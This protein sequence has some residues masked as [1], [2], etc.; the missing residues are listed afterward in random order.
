MHV[1]FFPRVLLQFLIAAVC[2]GIAYCA[3][4]NAEYMQTLRSSLL[5]YRYSWLM[6]VFEI[7][8]AGQSAKK[9]QLF[10]LT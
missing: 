4:P 9:S 10:I 6:M 7:A 1:G 8:K 5:Y 2:N 3:F